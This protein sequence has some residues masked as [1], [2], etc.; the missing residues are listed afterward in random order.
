MDLPEK[1]NRTGGDP[2]DD[3]RSCGCCGTSSGAD[4][5]LH[6]P[7]HGIARRA[8][9]GG[10]PGR[11]DGTFQIHAGLFGRSGRDVP[12]PYGPR[13]VGTGGQRPVDRTGG[14]TGGSGWKSEGGGEAGAAG[15]CGSG[16]A[17]GVCGEGEIMQVALYSLSD[18]FQDATE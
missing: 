6:Q 4:P 12:G 8:R 13:R 14:R 18:L 5:V 9:A 2:H 11:A 15:M 3:F 1:E 17:G 16:Y 7:V 10:H